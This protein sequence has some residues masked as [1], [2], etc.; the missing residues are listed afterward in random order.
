MKLDDEVKVRAGL[1]SSGI[2]HYR[3]QNLPTYDRIF[4][5]VAIVVTT[6]DHLVLSRGYQRS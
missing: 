4:T 3:K 6:P 5:V 2:V 1:C